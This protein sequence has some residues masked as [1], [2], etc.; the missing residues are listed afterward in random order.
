MG[1][2]LSLTRGFGADLSLAAAYRSMLSWRRRTIPMDA[3][4][5]L[6]PILYQRSLQGR[7]CHR[8]SVRACRALQLPVPR[9]V[10][11]SQR[12]PDN[13]FGKEVKPKLGIT[14][15]L[16]AN[17]RPHRSFGG[18]LLRCASSPT[19]APGR[20]KRQQWSAPDL[21]PAYRS[22]NKHAEHARP[23]P[24]HECFSYSIVYCA[25]DQVLVALKVVAFA[26]AAV[27]I[28]RQRRFQRSW[29]PSTSPKPAL[30]M[31]FNRSTKG[32]R[33]E[34]R[35]CHGIGWRAGRNW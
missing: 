16:K 30:A 32:L 34:M 11:L 31:D 27:Q 18:L 29:L 2:L 10:R 13:D 24:Q 21:H 35:Q 17:N 9:S 12:D 1:P 4:G 15:A 19:S 7:A 26:C 8:R 5:G 28:R 20:V 6:A 33:I 14:G 22:R 3:G 23:R 25:G